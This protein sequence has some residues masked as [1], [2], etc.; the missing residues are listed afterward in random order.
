MISM[1]IHFTLVLVTKR[2][3]IC[4]SL[5]FLFVLYHFVEL[6]D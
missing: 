6:F 5:S 2:E 4:V 3:V 1:M